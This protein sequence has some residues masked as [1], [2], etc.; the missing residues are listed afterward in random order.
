M[1]QRSFVHLIK[2]EFSNSQYN[3]AD[4]SLK[5]YKDLHCMEKV[6]GFTR[7]LRGALILMLFVSSNTVYVCV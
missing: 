4:I 5:K 6:K 1:Q 7:N 2:R 3:S